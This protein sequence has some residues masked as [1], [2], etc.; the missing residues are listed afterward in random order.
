MFGNRKAGLVRE[1]S[2]I[3]EEAVRGNLKSILENIKDKKIKGEIVLVV[4]GYRRE[5]IKDFSEEDIKVELLGLLKDGIS[6]KNALKIIR[7]RYDIDKQRLY[8]IATKI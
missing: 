5:L 7:S 2:K 8:N 6:K 4:E 1:I 3:Y